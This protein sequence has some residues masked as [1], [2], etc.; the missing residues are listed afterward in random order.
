M[1]R[2]RR[3]AKVVENV[4]IERAGAEGKA[5][6]HVDG[7]VVFV[8]FG[9]PGDIATLSVKKSHRKYMEGNILEL[10]KASE[11][12]TEPFCEHLPQLLEVLFPFVDV[13]KNPRV[14]SGPARLERH[15][16]HHA[17]A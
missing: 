17:R 6:A 10:T 13:I 16:Q 7:K 9:A 1:G 12:R 2:K 4:L 5:I 14:R 3:E 8:P 15:R 11:Q